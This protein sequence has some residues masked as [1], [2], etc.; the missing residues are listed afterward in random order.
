MVIIKAFIDASI[1]KDFYNCLILVKT[2]T[3]NISTGKHL[4]ERIYSHIEQHCISSPTFECVLKLI[5]EYC[6]T[7]EFAASFGQEKG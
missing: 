7:K 5:D 6:K 3:N 4:N 1:K 2:S